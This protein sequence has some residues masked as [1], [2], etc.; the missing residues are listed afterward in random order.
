MIDLNELF[1]TGRTG[2]IY[3]D[4]GEIKNKA[5]DVR[6][7]A[8]MEARNAMAMTEDGRRKLVG[9]M[10]KKEKLWHLKKL[11]IKLNDTE[12]KDIDNILIEAWE[13]D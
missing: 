6:K 8:V 1:T 10:S 7:A 2:E 4:I 11:G 9:T 12:K 13:D 3:I 5:V